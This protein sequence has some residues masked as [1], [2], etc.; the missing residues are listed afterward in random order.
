MKFLKFIFDLFMNMFL[1]T[2]V[3]L[4]Y[5]ATVIFGNLFGFYLTAEYPGWVTLVYLVLLIPT[6]AVVWFIGYIVVI[7]AVPYVE[8]MFPMDTSFLEEDA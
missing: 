2:L 1:G 4:F 5:V 3:V 7:K 8:K 6:V